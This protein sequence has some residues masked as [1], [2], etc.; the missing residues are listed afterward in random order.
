[1][2]IEQEPC[3]QRPENS[4]KAAGA[5]TTPRVPPRSVSGDKFETSPKRGGRV[6]PDPMAIKATSPKAATNGC[7]RLKTVR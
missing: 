5:W 6:R 2:T 4:R 1:M 3:K 7:R